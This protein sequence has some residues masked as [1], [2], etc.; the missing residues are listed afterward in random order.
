M[1]CYFLVIAKYSLIL[2]AILINIVICSSGF[3]EIIK[4]LDL[5]WLKTF[6]NNIFVILSKNR[7][8]DTRFWKNAPFL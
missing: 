1:L 5:T 2:Q 4:A 7:E 8:E 3:K 6:R